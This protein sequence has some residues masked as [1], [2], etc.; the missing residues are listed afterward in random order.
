M[1]IVDRLLRD[2]PKFHVHGTTRWDSLPGTLRAIQRAANDAARTLETGCGASTVIFAAQGAHH[3]VVSPDAEEH[4]RVR[5]Y[6]R[7]I[8]VDD[9]RLVSKIGPSDVVLPEICKERT[10]DAAYIDGAHSFPYPALDWHYISRGLKIGGQLIMDDIPI[11]ST[12][13]VFRFMQSDPE[14]RLDA[15]LDDRAA[16]FTLICEPPAVEDYTLQPFNRRPDYGF[17]GFPARVRLTLTSEIQGIRRAIGLRYPGL[18]RAW[19][20]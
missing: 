12:A 5:D 16:A 15:I 2:R 13:Y 8:G 17:A 14:W 7:Q 18:R 3:T 9:S 19:R 6:L 10:L 4:Q 20:R 1:D 11:P